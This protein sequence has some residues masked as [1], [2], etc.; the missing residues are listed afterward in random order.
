MLFWYFF[1]YNCYSIYIPPP[2]FMLDKKW[3]N[4][5]K[6]EAYI[7]KRV[8]YLVL[9]F[10]FDGGGVNS[11]L[12]KLYDVRCGGRSWHLEIWKRLEYLWSCHWKRISWWPFSLYLKSTVLSWTWAR[13]FY[14]IKADFNH[15]LEPIRIAS[16]SFVLIPV[17]T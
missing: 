12:G 2:L 4:I 17:I 7:V 5:C 3:T 13:R 14:S 9:L 15:P 1:F 16:I 8:L 10:L 6:Y 11:I